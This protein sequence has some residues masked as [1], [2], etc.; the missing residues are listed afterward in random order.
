MFED[1]KKLF[2]NDRYAKQSEIQI[3]EI[4][5]GYAKCTMPVTE[6]HLN[7]NNSIMGGALFTLGDFCFSIAAN[8]YGTQAVS[9]NANIS[10]IRPCSLGDEITA[11]ATEI[12]R[13]RKIGIYKVSMHNKEGKLIAEM[14]GTSFFKD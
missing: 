5:E 6:N 1:I 9:L 14:N 7:G 13:T 2:G 3:V 12:S 11:E 4:A 8:S 10:Y